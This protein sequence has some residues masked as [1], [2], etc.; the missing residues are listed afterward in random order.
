MTYG[1][2]EDV[3]SFS[4]FFPFANFSIGGSLGMNWTCL[5]GWDAPL[6][7]PQLKNAKYGLFSECAERRR[8]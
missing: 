2:G 3:L 5:C 4:T 6:N 1:S 7:G 8:R